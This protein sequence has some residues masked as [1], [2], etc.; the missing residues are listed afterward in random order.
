MDFTKAIMAKHSK[1]VEEYD[2]LILSRV[3]D[4]QWVRANNSFNRV[5]FVS[6]NISVTMPFVLKDAA[7][8][9]AEIKT[10]FTERG[11]RVLISTATHGTNI[12]ITLGK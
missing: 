11:W 8:I 1:E 6:N 7:I 5:G 4:P 10:R 3:N 12:E 9:F 2:K